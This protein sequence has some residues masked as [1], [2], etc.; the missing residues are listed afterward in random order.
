MKKLLLTVKH[1]WQLRGLIPFWFAKH[2]HEWR[3]RR[4]IRAGKCCRLMI[5]YLDRPTRYIFYPP[6]ML[7]KP[8]ELGRSPEGYVIGW[9]IDTRTE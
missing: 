6:G 9:T 4:N 3:Y 2:W 8:P 1:L 7:P 5:Q